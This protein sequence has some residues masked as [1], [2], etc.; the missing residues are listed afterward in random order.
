MTDLAPGD[1]V[2]SVGEYD[3]DTKSG[4]L[5]SSPKYGQIPFWINPGQTLWVVEFEDGSIH[6]CMPEQM[7]KTKRK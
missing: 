3:F 7:T 5:F 1:V 2:I 6:I 4:K